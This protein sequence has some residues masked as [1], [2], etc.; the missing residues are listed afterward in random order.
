MVKELSTRAQ[1]EAGADPDYQF[2]DLGNAVRKI[3]LDQGVPIEFE[4]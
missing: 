1:S 2:E 4:A 3:R